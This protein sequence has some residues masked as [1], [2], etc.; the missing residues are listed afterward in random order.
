MARPAPVV[1]RLRSGPRAIGRRKL[2]GSFGLLGLSG[3]E[4]VL[5]VL[6]LLFVFDGEGIG[7]KI[8]VEADTIT[9]GLAQERVDHRRGGGFS[10]CP[11]LSLGQEDV[12]LLVAEAFWQLAAGER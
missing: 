11:C 2:R 3:E 10:L 9:V 12:D 6:L 7:G 5:V 8:A 1:E 4:R